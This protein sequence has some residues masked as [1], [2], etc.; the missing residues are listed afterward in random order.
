MQKVPINL[1]KPGMVLAK[2]VVNEKG[3]ALC[4]E[5]TELTATLI[6]RLMRMNVSH[7]TLKGSPV[8]MGDPG[9]SVEEKI[10][11]MKDRFARVQGDPVMDKIRDAI[12]QALASE[13]M[14]QPNEPEE[15]GKG[16][17]GE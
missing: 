15:E 6:D 10:R 16:E 12:A 17:P 2:P 1:V 8:E 5:G 9:K 4:A 7:L 13:F 3:M 11:E 14:E